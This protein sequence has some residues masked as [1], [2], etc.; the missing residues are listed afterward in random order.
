MI[1]TPGVC[2]E[3]H[4]FSSGSGDHGSRI[5]GVW[6]IGAYGWSGLLA[7]RH[8]LLLRPAVSC[9][10]Q[11]DADNRQ[12]AQ[13]GARH[14]RNALTGARLLGLETQRRWGVQCRAAGSARISFCPKPASCER[15]IAK[16]ERQKNEKDGTHN[17]TPKGCPKAALKSED[18]AP[19]NSQQKEARQRSETGLGCSRLRMDFCAHL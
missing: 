11:K 8:F 10:E 14:I 17:P 3:A 15:R 7:D 13:P 4:L 2:P 16:T 1:R 18:N 9:P 12:K 6:N 5:T 19:A